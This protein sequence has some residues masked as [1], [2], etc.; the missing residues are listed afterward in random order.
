MGNDDAVLTAAMAY[1]ALKHR[2]I[3]RF[4]RQNPRKARLIAR[5]LPLLESKSSPTAT[6]PCPVLRGMILYGRLLQEL[7][8]ELGNE[9][10]DWRRAAQLQLWIGMLEHAA[11][12]KDD[13]KLQESEL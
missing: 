1:Q 5:R 12:M 13:H 10:P 4:T 6:E 2:I 7:L 11:V 8:E 9:I 3:G